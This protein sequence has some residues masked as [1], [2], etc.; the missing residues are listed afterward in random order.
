MA[1]S[2][3]VEEQLQITKILAQ[4]WRPGSI[5]SIMVWYRRWDFMNWIIGWFLSRKVRNRLIH[6]LNGNSMVK[7][8]VKRKTKNFATSSFPVGDRS[9]ITKALAKLCGIS[10]DW[11][12]IK[13]G[14]R[15]NGKVADI[16][17]FVVFFWRSK[18]QRELRW[19]GRSFSQEMDLV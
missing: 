19:E 8:K 12:P 1:S 7:N 10:I 4:I 14:F 17:S 5:E 2:C 16:G 13:Y 18:I 9:L 6:M 11:I 15:F 3:R